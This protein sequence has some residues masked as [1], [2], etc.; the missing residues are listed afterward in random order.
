MHVFVFGMQIASDLSQ[1]CWHSRIAIA[2]F[3][4]EGR[5]S[6]PSHWNNNVVVCQ[7]LVGVRRVR[8]VPRKVSQG[9]LHAGAHERAEKCQRLAMGGRL[10]R[11]IG[12]MCL[13]GMD[14]LRA[15]AICN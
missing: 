5:Q 4:V 9:H 2:V 7:L 1:S 11:R 14:L 3:P 6:Q 10:A 8:T 15:S 12:M 13:F